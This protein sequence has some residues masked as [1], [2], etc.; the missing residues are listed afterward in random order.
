VDTHG[1]QHDHRIL[2][3]TTQLLDELVLPAWQMK[4]RT[5]EALELPFRRQSADIDD[6][7]VGVSPGKTCMFRLTARTDIR[8]LGECNSFF[9]GCIRIDDKAATKALYP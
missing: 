2:I 7:I 8:L 6:C 1:L 4:R 5:V 3:G 9:D